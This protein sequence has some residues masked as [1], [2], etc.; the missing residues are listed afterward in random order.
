[1]F[2]R[3]D[4]LN[5]RRLAAFFAF[6]LAFA[7]MIP[8]LTMMARAEE[9][10]VVDV[11]VRITNFEIRNLNKETVEKIHHTQT[12][13]LKMDWNADHLGD[14]LKSGDQFHIEL[15]DT[16]KFPAGAVQREFNLTRE[17][18]P[19]VVIGKGIIQPGPGDIGGTVT[20]TFNEKVEGKLNNH[21]TLWMGAQFNM[22]KLK[23]NEVNKFTVTVS[24]VPITTEMTPYLPGPIVNEDLLKWGNPDSMDPHVVKWGARINH[25]KHDH[26]NAV[27]TDSLSEGMGDETYIPGSFIL[28]E[29][30]YSENG[31]QSTTLK[32]IDLIEGPGGNFTLAPDKRS[33]TI[34]LGDISGKQL[35]LRYSTTYTKPGKQLKNKLTLNSDQ[36][37]DFSKTYTYQSAESGGTGSNDDASKIKLKKVDATD[38]TITLKG[39]VF[40]VTKPDGQTFRLTTGD[41]GTATSDALVAGQQYKVKEIEAPKGYIADETEHVLTV[42]ADSAAELTVQNKRITIDIPVE[43]FW[44]D[45]GNQAGLRPQEVEVQLV[46]NDKDV[47]GQ[48]RT[49]V[50]VNNWKDEFK[51]VP[52]FDTDGNLIKYTV[53]ELN[54][55]AEYGVTVTGD[56][57]GDASQG[58]SITNSYVPEVVRLPVKKKWLGPGADSVKVQLLGRLDDAEPYED[59]PGAVLTLTKD[60]GWQGS[61]ENLPKLKEGKLVSY[62][63]K[64]LDVDT[65]KY[66]VEIDNKGACTVYRATEE[67]GST[68]TNRNIEK[69]DISGVKTWNDDDDRD[70]KRP[71]E[72]TVKLLA[73]GQPVREETVTAGA[74]GTWA[75]SFTGLPKYTDAGGQ[76]AYSVDEVKVPGYEKAINGTDITNTYS[77]ETVDIP[78][79]KVWVGPK[80]SEVTVTLLADGQ[81]VPDKSLVLNAGNSWKGSFDGLP[82]NKDGNPIVY[83]VTEA[84]VAGVDTSKYEVTVSDFVPC[85]LPRGDQQVRADAECGFTITNKNIEKVKVEGVKT[86]D[87]DNDRDGKRP[88]EITVRLKTK[89]GEQASQ[90]VTAA[91]NW[92][93]S[94]TDLP[95]YTDKG[96]EIV[97]TV[98][99][100]AVG[101]YATKIDADG[102]ITNSYTP[103]KTSVSVSKV[104]DD[105]DNQDGVRPDSVKV[106]LKADEKALGEPV[107][108]NADNKWTHT[109][110]DLFIN[111]NGK[112]IGYT[113]EE[114]DVPQGYEAKV[115]GDAQKGYTVTNTHVP[116]QVSIPVV[117]KWEGKTGASATF[118]LY[119]GKDDTG[120]VLTLDAAV[121]WKGSFDGL[122]KFKDGKEIAYTITEDALE[123]YE[124][125][126]KGDMRDGFTVTNTYVDKKLAKTGLSGSGLLLGSTILGGAGAVML[127]VR[128]KREQA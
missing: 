46:A 70:R 80:G 124:A 17:D 38:P 52:K 83:T 13:L 69:V 109:W 59:V 75:Y 101:E 126:V 114:V 30:E 74:D 89:D 119:A 48:R 65:S 33:F 24:K 43:K 9:G 68:I 78:V 41:D 31:E 93:Y 55:P 125:K 100:D 32:T 34:R 1:M 117:K 115:E 91:N 2:P 73:D 120:K 67:C 58:F 111:N 105:A 53:R 7:L 62:A 25:A 108:L 103:G 64:E 10:Q 88:G 36:I 98:T 44:E 26:K 113:V 81:P 28:E 16:M 40:E 110:T 47:E 8:G 79:K 84:Q 60:E 122:P 18:D 5:M 12:F 121:D 77:P 90:K 127:A 19:S 57:N 97:Y 37:K 104:W 29:R 107:V 92:A 112:K 56:P 86:W 66:Q 116:E 123:G 22:D 63:V 99:E 118:H 94:F 61:F 35:A 42:N 14:T 102:T 87:D 39:A 50:E 21:G 106:Q 11:D 20:V 3:S 4:R 49:L 23:V 82:K 128:R 51:N 45:K 15:P 6:I 71:K 76:I 27:I 54:P 96:D 85:A 95:K 72:I